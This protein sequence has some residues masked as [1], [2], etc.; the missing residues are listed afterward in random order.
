MTKMSELFFCEL[1]A[2]EYLSYDEQLKILFE[3][4]NFNN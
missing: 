2:S 1:L 4:N 3:H